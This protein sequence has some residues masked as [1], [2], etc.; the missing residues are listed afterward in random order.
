MRYGEQIF[1]I[2]VS[3]DGLDL[4]APGAIPQIM[5]RFHRRHEELYTYSIPDQEVVMVNARLTVVGELPETA[6]ERSSSPRRKHAQV[7]PR[8]HG[9]VY[10]DRW[11][12]VPIFDLTNLAPGETMEG[13]AIVEAPTTTVLLRR[14]ERASVTRLGWL[15]TQVASG[16]GEHG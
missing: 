1:E 7:R 14:N 15:D 10:L 4:A 5:E 12:Q 6:A 11:Q 9:R 2:N 3:L 8:R 16:D 13:P